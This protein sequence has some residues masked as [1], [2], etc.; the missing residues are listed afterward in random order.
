MKKLFKKLILIS[1]LVFCFI[2][3]TKAQAT[4]CRTQ[5]CPVCMEVDFI[6]SAACGSAVWWWTYGAYPSGC[7]FLPTWGVD[8]NT[9]LGVFGP[10][11]QCPGDNCQCPSGIYL[12]EAGSTVPILNLNFSSMTT[13]TPPATYPYTITFSVTPIVCA[14]AFSFVDVKVINANY[15]QIT[16]R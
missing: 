6:G 16:V 7:G 4:M 3:K 11:A 10:C 12:L 15:I 1:L 13:P 9:H 14:G 5:D 2:N 8:G